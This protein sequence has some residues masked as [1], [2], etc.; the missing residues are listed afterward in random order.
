MIQF[1]SDSIYLELLISQVKGS[2]PQECLTLSQIQVSYNSDW[3]AL[4]RGYHKPFPGLNTFLNQLKVL[5]ETADL[6]DD[7]FIIKHLTPQQPN[8]QDAWSEVWERGAKLSDPVKV[9][10][11]HISYM[12][13]ANWKLS[14]LSY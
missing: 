3:L 1:V 4:N 11:P 12:C 14:K 8:G 6:L 2:F 7:W 13:S 10:H 5:K 9:H